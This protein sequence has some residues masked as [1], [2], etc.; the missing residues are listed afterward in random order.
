M[1]TQIKSFKTIDG[2]VFTDRKEAVKHDFKLQF[3][4]LVQSKMLASQKSASYTLIEIAD[5]IIESNGEFINLFK[6]FNMAMGQL[7]RKK[8]SEQ[9][10]KETLTSE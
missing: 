2:R 4:G 9:K 10:E 8:S 3:R 6:R 1:I 5:A 7:N